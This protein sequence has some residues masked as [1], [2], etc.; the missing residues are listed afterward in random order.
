M[1]RLLMEYGRVDLIIK[2]DGLMGLALLW[3]RL[4][5]FL[6]FFQ[7]SPPTFLLCWIKLR[8]PL[9]SITDSAK[10]RSLIPLDFDH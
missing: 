8:I 9:T 6:K 1:S 2:G 10:L 5:F 3:R 7:K 4:P